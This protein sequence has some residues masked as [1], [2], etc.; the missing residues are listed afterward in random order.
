[1]VIF[2]QQIGVE[3]NILLLKTWYKIALCDLNVLLRFIL[4]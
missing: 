1:M 3:H 2:Y 4:V